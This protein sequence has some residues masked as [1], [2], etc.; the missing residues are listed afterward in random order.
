MRGRVERRV[1]DLNAPRP[2]RPSPPRPP[3]ASPPHRPPTRPALPPTLGASHRPRLLPPLA[4]VTP[5]PPAPRPPPDATAVTFAPA[6]A[7]SDAPPSPPWPPPP[8]PRHA[9]PPRR[10]PCPDWTPPHPPRLPPRRHHPPH[11]PDATTLLRLPDLTRLRLAPDTQATLTH[12]RYDHADARAT[13]TLHLTTGALRVTAN[14]LERRHARTRITFPGGALECTHADFELAITPTGRGHLRVERGQLTLTTATRTLPLPA[15]HAIHL[16]PQDALPVPLLP[17]P[18]PIAPSPA[19]TPAPSSL[20][21]S[22][23]HCGP[24]RARHRHRL[25]RPPHP[26]PHPT[27][28]RPRY[29]DPDR[30]Y[31][32]RVRA[33]DP[34]GHHGHPAPLHAFAPPPATPPPGRARLAPR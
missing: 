17:A 11:R 10:R 7:A 25:R 27:P 33:I 6:A 2:P 32:W 29:L 1:A 13:T 4:A 26:R 23:R 30:R 15:G 19:A 20:A 14:P 3:A 5:S 31:Y 24:R 9:A 34:T 28:L 21:P 12:L 16:G 22:R 18:T 8:T